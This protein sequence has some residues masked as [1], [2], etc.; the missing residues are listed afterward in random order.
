[1]NLDVR[2]A[3]A[4]QRLGRFVSALVEGIALLYASGLSLGL[5]TAPTNDPPNS[6]IG[7]IATTGIGRIVA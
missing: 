4:K 6:P 1:V 3:R 5:I 7:F 2:G